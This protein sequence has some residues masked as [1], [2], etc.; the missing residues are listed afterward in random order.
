MNHESMDGDISQLIKLLK[1]ILK[2]HPQG[3][4][5]S[6]LMEQ[7]AMNV[8]LCFLTFIPMSA[9]E[10]DDF[11]NYKVSFRPFL[12]DDG[13]PLDIDGN[14]ISKSPIDNAKD[15]FIDN[16]TDNPIDKKDKS[17]ND[18]KTKK[19]STIPKKRGRPKNKA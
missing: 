1:K 6:K 16:L 17:S 10:L 13:N 5:V 15:N 4:E 9:E 14:I 3:Q 11:G 2:N 7:K 8:N 12:D 18:E 19:P